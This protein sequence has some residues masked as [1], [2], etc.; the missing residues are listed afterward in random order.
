M[1]KAFDPFGDIVAVRVVRDAVTNQS[2]GYGFV[3]FKSKIDAENAMGKMQGM[4]LLHFPIVISNIYIP[5][6]L[7][8]PRFYYCVT[9]VHS[10]RI[11]NFCVEFFFLTNLNQ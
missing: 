6:Y 2:K 3:S 11:N 1:R 5:S 10:L 4:M 7:A 8:L 9:Q